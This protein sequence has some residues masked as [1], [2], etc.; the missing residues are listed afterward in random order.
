[1]LSFAHLERLWI[2]FS[3]RNSLIA[4]PAGQLTQGLEIVIRRAHVDI[5]IG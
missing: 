3:F 5:L 1:M 4:A 2:E